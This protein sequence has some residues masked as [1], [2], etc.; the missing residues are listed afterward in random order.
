MIG[1]LAISIKNKSVFSQKS[2]NTD[3]ISGKSSQDN[4][5]N[6]MKIVAL[7]MNIQKLKPKLL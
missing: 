2:S 7:T 5:M 3:N 1:K 6:A 4:L